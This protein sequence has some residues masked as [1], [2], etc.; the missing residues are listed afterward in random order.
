MKWFVVLVFVL[1]CGRL[2]SQEERGKSLATFAGGC[3]W[4][5]EPPFE[6]LPGVHSVKSGYTGGKD[7]DPDYKQ[8]S[9]GQSTHREA[10]QIQYDP[11]KISYEELLR[12]FWQQ[13]DPTDGGGQFVDRGRQ[14]TTAIYFHT[15][16]QKAAASKSLGE[17]SRSGRFSRPIV[18]EI[19][20]AV[21]F[22]PAEDYHQDYYKK[23]PDNYYR[24]RN[25]SGRDAFLKKHWGSKTTWKEF[26]RPADKEL[27]SRLNPLQ[28]R[29]TRQDGTEPPFRNEYWNQKEPGIYV[30][31][32]SGE[33]LFSSRDKYDSGTGWPSF[34]RPLLAQLIKEIPDNS[35]G[36]KRVEVRSKLAD[37]HLGHVFDDGPPP[38]GLRYCINSAA[39]R[40]I[41]R[42]QMAE[43]GYGEFL[44]AL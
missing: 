29:V 2:A 28:F 32:V 43:E 37:S 18:T 41:P 20:P 17:L 1:G 11:A 24:Y 8:V 15:A 34:R 21:R 12:V 27:R 33:P 35:Q 9:S 39:M 6:K 30:D 44:S 22:Y 25:G 7:P 14:Y 16:E 10:V 38:E 31:I 42:S 40:F 23:S 4:C 5:M 19:L 36:M 13:I 3:F 26:L